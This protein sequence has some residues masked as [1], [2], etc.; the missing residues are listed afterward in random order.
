M[1][2]QCETSL[3]YCSIYQA[4][5]SK[6]N[7]DE[8]WAANTDPCR[9]IGCS[10]NNVAFPSVCMSYI[11][12][13]SYTSYVI[14]VSIRTCKHVCHLVI[15]DFFASRRT[16]A[17]FLESYTKSSKTIICT[18][19]NMVFETYQKKFTLKLTQEQLYKLICNILTHS[20]ICISYDFQISW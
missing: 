12:V 5:V 4:L 20:S 14:P 18:K 11:C 13:I 19:C 7:T 9:V 6:L 8:R 15:Y 10:L 1:V 2:P 17:C 16:G 3:E